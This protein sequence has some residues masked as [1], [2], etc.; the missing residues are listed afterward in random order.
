MLFSFWHFAYLLLVVA[1]AVLVSVSLK[2]KSVMAKEKMLNRISV[3]LRLSYLADFL[4]TTLMMGRLSLTGLPFRVSSLSAVLIFL[5]RFVKPVSRFREPVMLT[6]L[7]AALLYLVFPDTAARAGVSAGYDAVQN[8][9]LHGLLTIYGVVAVATGSIKVSVKNVY[10]VAALMAGIVVWG[11]VG[12]KLYAA[13]TPDVRGL[14]IS[15]D[16]SWIVAI[17]A[18]LVFTAVAAAVCVTPSVV[19]KLKRER[20]EE[21]ATIYIADRRAV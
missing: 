4:A 5:T 1:A 8:M 3:L 12:C 11:T 21:T 17:G 7:A 9:V 14:I 6:G 13:E 20:K 15:Q 10:Q 18:I 16:H 19:S 2:G